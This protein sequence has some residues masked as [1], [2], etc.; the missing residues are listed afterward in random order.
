MCYIDPDTIEWSGS[1]GG[2][3]KLYQN[4]KWQVRNEIAE[5]CAWAFLD[6]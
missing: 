4:Y 1:A 5:K 6:F 3:M 2:Q